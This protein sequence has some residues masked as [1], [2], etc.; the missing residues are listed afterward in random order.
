MEVSESKIYVGN[1]S[2][3][4][5]QDQL[6]ELFSE[7]GE[8]TEVTLITDKFSGRSKGFGFIVFAKKEDAEKAIAKMNEKEIEGRELK[9]SKAKPVDPDRP[10]GR[11]FNRRRF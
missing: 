10:R 3:S 2:F 9:V 4:V 7:F 11:D 8:I 6:R 1:L 5:S